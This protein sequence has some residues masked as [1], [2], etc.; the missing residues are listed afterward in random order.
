M[1]SIINLRNPQDLREIKKCSH[2][3]FGDEADF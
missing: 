1:F 2:V 3:D